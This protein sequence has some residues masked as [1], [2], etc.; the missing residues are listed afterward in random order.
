M[1]KIKNLFYF[2][3]VFVC[4]AYIFSYFVLRQRKYLIHFCRSGVHSVE[5]DNEPYLWAGI[6]AVMYAKVCG[7]T[8]DVSLKKVEMTTIS[9]LKENDERLRCIYW[10]LIEG[11]LVVWNL[12]GTDGGIKEKQKRQSGRN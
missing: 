9:R 11:E 3:V 6:E 4:V 8:N 2:I 7:M 10:P 5:C 12:F 1:L